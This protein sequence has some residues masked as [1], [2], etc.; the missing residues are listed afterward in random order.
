[1][2]A[3]ALLLL[4]P[5]FTLTTACAGGPKRIDPGGDGTVTSAGVDYNEIIE[6]TDTLTQRML[7]SGFLDSGEFGTK[8]VKMVVSQ[9]QNKT[10]L[11][12]FPHEILL[13]NIRS[14]LLSSG[15][16]RFVSTYG[17]DG[18]DQI[19]RDTQELKNDP[20]FDSSQ[21]PE[22]GQ[23]TVARLGMATEILWTRSQGVDEAQNTY[24]VFMQ[25]TDVKNG[26]VIWEGRSDPI[27]KVYKK[28]TVSW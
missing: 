20:L 26:E 4:L 5:L 3:K 17:A 22:S 27:A 19:T 12:H 28:G 13:G 16:A 23:A 18:T 25:V 14:A 8:P 10:D 7:S 2:N 1:M 15:K 21:V 24:V 11:S 6:W 9:V